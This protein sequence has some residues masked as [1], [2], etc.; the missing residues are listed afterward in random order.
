MIDI[1][2]GELLKDFTRIIAVEMF[3]DEVEYGHYFDPSNIDGALLEPAL[4]H[5]Q[6]APVFRNKVN[7][8]RSR[9]IATVLEN[10]LDSF[11]RGVQQD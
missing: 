1:N 10:E 8:L 6:N 2:K 9:L 3:R 4:S 5:Y 7:H 11:V